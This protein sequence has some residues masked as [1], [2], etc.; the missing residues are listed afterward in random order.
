[1]KSFSDICMKC[2][3]P[4]VKINKMINEHTVNYHPSPSELTSRIHP[5]IF[6]WTPRGF[7]FTPECFLNFLKPI[8]RT[9]VAEKFQI[10]GVKITGKCIFWVKKLNLFIFTYVPKQK[11]LP[12]S[13][14]YYC[15]QEE[16][17]HFPQKWFF[18]FPQQKG[19][20]IMELKKWPKLNL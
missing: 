17:N 18:I 19:R 4:Q 1:M 5:L 12:D 10:P 14:H 16:V 11:S 7:I 20:K 8:F 9:M 6:L 3:N 2:L 13:Y 15:R